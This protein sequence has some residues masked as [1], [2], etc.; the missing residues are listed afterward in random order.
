MLG[1]YGHPTTTSL[2]NVS[3][4]QNGAGFNCIPGKRTI[5]INPKDFQWIQ[6]ARKSH[7]QEHQSGTQI[8]VW[9]L[10]FI[11]LF[12]SANVSQSFVTE[13]EKKGFSDECDLDS[14]PVSHRKWISV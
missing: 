11:R 8:S 4:S 12:F 5:Q 10:F 1:N 7:F 14:N 2:E 9:R 13:S 3:A 6:F